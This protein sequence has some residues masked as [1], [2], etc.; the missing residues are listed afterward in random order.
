VVQQTPG[1]GGAIASAILQ[2][3]ATGIF[4]HVTFLELVPS[5]FHNQKDRLAKVAFHFL[6]FLSLAV[7]TVTMG[8]HH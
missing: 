7:V 6:G 8:S 4:I 2:S 5:E 1:T 3:L